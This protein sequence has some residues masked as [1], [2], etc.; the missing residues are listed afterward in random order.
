MNFDLTLDS[1]SFEDKRSGIRRKGDK[2]LCPGVRRPGNLLP[3]N[4]AGHGRFRAFRHFRSRGAGRPGP[5]T[6]CPTSSPPKK[7]PGWTVL[8]RRDH[9]RGQF[10]GDRSHLLFRIRGAK[11]EASARALRGGSPVGLRPDRAPGRVRR[12]ERPN[13]GCPGGRRMGRER[14]QDIHYQRFDR[15]NGR[16]S[17]SSVRPEWAWTAARNCPACWWKA[18]PRASRPRPCRAR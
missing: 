17:P 11:A 18:G 15:D 7:S 4:H 1:G 16:G 5:G 2:A 3:Q 6:T 14:P 10:P 13:H 12:R 9:G 8:T